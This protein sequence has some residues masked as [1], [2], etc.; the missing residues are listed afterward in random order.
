M[1]AARRRRAQQTGIGAS[2]FYGATRVFSNG[3]RAKTTAHDAPADIRLSILS[4][5][6]DRNVHGSII[7]YYPFSPDTHSYFFFFCFEPASQVLVFGARPTAPKKDTRK[8]PR[9]NR[10]AC[11]SWPCRVPRSV[12]YTCNVP[13]LVCSVLRENGTVNVFLPSEVQTR[14]DWRRGTSKLWLIISIVY[15]CTHGAHI[16][17]NT[18]EHNDTCDRN[19]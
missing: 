15:W 5:K 6:T 11:S 14:R 18:H 9:M 19:T 3:S 13:L 10:Q 1:R 8:K 17:W 2:Y 4:L 12:A 7:K 16:V